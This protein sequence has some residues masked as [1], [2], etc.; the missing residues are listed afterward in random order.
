MVGMS[1]RRPM[2]AGKAIPGR[3]AHP[4]WVMDVP[5]TTMGFVPAGCSLPG[6]RPAPSGTPISR[7]AMPLYSGRYRIHSRRPGASPVTSVRS[8]SSSVGRP[9]ATQIHFPSSRT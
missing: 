9:T 3:L 8:F 5:Y 1:R 2:M 7:L 6:A 4:P